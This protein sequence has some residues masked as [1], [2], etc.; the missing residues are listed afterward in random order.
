MAN[1]IDTV[2]SSTE[3]PLQL[4]DIM[5]KVK[6]FFNSFHKT[7]KSNKSSKAFS[8]TYKD[9]IINI[10]VALAVLWVAIFYWI[11]V[12]REYQD[13]NWK[14]EDLKKISTYDVR[15]DESSLSSYT[16]WNDIWTINWM[17]SVYNNIE[18]TI[19]WYDEFEKQQRSY[20]EV[21]LQNIY[22]PSVNVWKDP[23][24]KNFD[25]SIL[26]QK[27]LEMDKFQDLY[28][29]QYWSDFFKYVWNDADYNQVE[30]I[31]IWSKVVLEDN[32]DYF[33]TPISV[34]FTS[35]N[36]RSFLL[37]V[38]KLSVTSNQSNISLLNEFFFYLLNSIKEQKKN[39]IDGLMEKYRTMFS[40]SSDWPYSKELSELTD[41]E[42]ET[43]KNQVIGYNLYHRIN[44]DGLVDKQ[45]SLVD[46]EIIVNTIKQATLCSNTDS[47][48]KCFYNFRDKY[49]NLPYLAY[50]I[51]LEKQ[52]NR[53]EGLLRFLQ[54][55]PPAIA[56]T[57]FWFE[58]YSNANFLNNEWER[59]EW[60]ITFKAYWRNITS[61]ELD[62]AATLLWKL[63]LWTNSDK[64]MSPELGLS[65]VNENMLLLWW[66]KQYSNVSS[67]WELKSIFEQL[68]MDYESLTN[69]DKMIKL[70]E[71]W[72]MMNDA[73][74][75]S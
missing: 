33:Y 51:W 27:Y 71:M 31:N 17:L 55:L 67:L 72:R 61:S 58:K 7:E 8:L 10:L 53:S 48:Q 47:D 60:D 56:I 70:F 37:L 1:E 41:N 13:I 52:A 35:P 5:S 23:Y 59:Y 20:Y 11:I 50:N 46:D 64:Q 62:E 73:N 19:K 12:L 3:W 39:M 66:N 18:D 4:S 36:K 69:Y 26:W 32:P 57:D 34:T 63:C 6:W 54:D 30:S 24:T 45:S 9:A 65:K 68:Q 28:L 43:Y 29:I 2:K 15:I 22:L 74:L 75:C 49:R 16:E 44:D 25:L 21:L 40:S 42:R 38:N 14:T